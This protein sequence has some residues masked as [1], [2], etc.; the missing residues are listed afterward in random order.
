MVGFTGSFVVNVTLAFRGPI[1]DG[2]NVIVYVTEV[3]GL[4]VLPVVGE[5]VKSPAS[6][7]VMGGFAAIVRG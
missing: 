1:A 4:T 2:S 3:A 7:P 5:M 6:E